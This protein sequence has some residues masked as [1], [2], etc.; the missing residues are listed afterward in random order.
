MNTDSGSKDSKD[1]SFASL[2]AAQTAAQPRRRKL[3]PGDEV[4]L[5]EPTYDSYAPCVAM[6]GGVA[7][8]IEIGRAF[9]EGDAR[10]AATGGDA[11]LLLPHVPPVDLHD[12]A[13]VFRGLAF[14]ARDALKND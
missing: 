6:A 7:R 9:F 13:L 5:F 2:F 10:V 14:A 3:S 8:M 11:A 12:P 1:E 4:V